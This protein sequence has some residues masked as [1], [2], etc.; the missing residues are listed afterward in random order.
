M[1]HERI[2]NNIINRARTRKLDGYKELHH[3]TPRCLGGLDTDDNLVYLT[4]KEHFI[5]HA[6]LC[7]IHKGNT[8]LLYAFNIMRCNFNGLRYR[9]GINYQKFKLELSKDISNRMKGNKHTLGFKFS[10]KSRD[11]MSKSQLNSPYNKSRSM[12]CKERFIGHTHNNGRIHSAESTA[13]M[14]KG[15]LGNKNSSTK[16]ICQYCKTETIKSN[17]INY[18]GPNPSN[19][20]VN[21]ET[22]KCR[23]L[24]LDIGTSW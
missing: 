11:K 4:A 10:E 8:K 7:H 20:K 6:L 9:S 12:V 13:N 14:S 2:Y 5:C 23:K 19:P 22:T 17:L 3:I 1:N 24:S 16:S 15:K 21:S 18:H